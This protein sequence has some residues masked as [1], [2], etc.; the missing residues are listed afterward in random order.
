LEFPGG[1]GVLYNQ[2]KLKEMYEAQS[3]LP[4][5]WERGRYRYFLELHIII[6][7]L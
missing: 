3:E 7:E 1:W 4:E 2:K 6:R 5:G